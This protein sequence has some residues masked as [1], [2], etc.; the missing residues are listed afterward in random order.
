MIAVDSSAVVA[1]LHE[2]PECKSFVECILR[3]GGAV[4]SAASI[5]EL[6]AVTAGKKLASR[7]LDEFLLTPFVQI[8]PVD[9]EQ[10]LIGVE[11]YRR[12]GRGQHP[13]RL[14]LGDAFAY[15]LA[16]RKNLPLLFK[17]D[18]FAKT[19]IEP[20]LPAESRTD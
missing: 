20:A 14:N 8:E 11:A 5:V 19:D 1:I 17:G 10:A 9:V 13:A 18:D 15:A 3:A 16:R 4:V 6:A 2:E 12:F 7:A